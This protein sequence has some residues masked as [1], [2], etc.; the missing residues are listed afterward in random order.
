MSRPSPY[1]RDELLTA[2]EGSLHPGGLRLTGRAVRLSGLNPGMRVADIG[3]GTGATCAYLAREYDLDVVGLEPSETLLAACRANHPELNVVRGVWESLP[4]AQER[5]DA[6]IAE[7]TLSLTESPEK[8]LA[9]SFDALKDGGTLIVSDLY[10]KTA[11]TAG[12]ESKSRRFSARDIRD[13]I[14]G[15][16]FDIVL[17]EDHTPAL[18][19]F[20]CALSERCGGMENMAALF[21]GQPASRF[22]GISL[23]DLG[24]LLVVAKKHDGRNSNE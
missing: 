17:T 23:R 22:A 14:L 13:L 10:I 12:H 2:R 4:F 18:K 8:A 15:A 1:E 19:T 7:C 9:R 24:Y 21:S 11:K 6:V 5:L 3:C 16:G 20:A